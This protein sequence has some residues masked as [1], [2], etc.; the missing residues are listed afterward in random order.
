MGIAHLQSIARYAA[1]VVGSRVDDIQDR[2]VGK[3]SRRVGSQIGQRTRGQA[4]GR[5][6]NGVSGRYHI[7]DNMQFGRRRRDSD[8]DI[9]VRVNS[10]SFRQSIQFRAIRLKRQDPSVSGARGRIELFDPGRVP[11][12]E[13]PLEINDRSASRSNGRG[14]FNL[15]V[16]ENMEFCPRIGGSDPNIAVRVNS[17]SF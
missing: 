14:R 16:S 15:R 13:R 2:L 8:P 17:H 3:G 12:V 4:H 1:R 5:V 9:A 6:V 10:H 11:V 7:V